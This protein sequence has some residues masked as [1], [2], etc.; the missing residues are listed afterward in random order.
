MI[1]LANFLTD[2][3]A[4][5]DHERLVDFFTRLI[6]SCSTV[7]I[8]IRFIYYPNN[9]QHEILFTYFLTG[10]IVFLVAS[11]LD[12]VEMEFGFALGLFAIFSII[13]FRT[14]PLD[15]KEM[16]YLF[17]SIGISAINALVDFKMADWQG[18]IISNLIILI[19]AFTMEKYRPR[20]VVLKKL[21]TFTASGLHVLNN[22]QLLKE[23]IK[24]KTNLNIFK[25]EIIKISESKNE[26]TV[27]IYFRPSEN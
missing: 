2:F 27:W 22:N 14:P 26:V 5:A 18:L 23:E 24:S 17:A 21:L 6:I 25:V 19:A 1:I 11:S 10:L 7:F 9:G 20:K 16:T 3:F 13:R 12:R 4:G 8:L 15:V